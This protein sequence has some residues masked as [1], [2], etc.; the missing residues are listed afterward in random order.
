MPTNKNIFEL[1]FT[2]EYSVIPEY[3]QHALRRYVCDRI[4]PGGFLLAVLQNDLKNAC[5][6]ADDDNLALLP[7]YV[8]WLYNVAPGCCWGS[9]DAVK[10][11]LADK[12]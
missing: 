1:Y 9:P 6:R 8:K 11:W 4:S 12:A 5:G 3:A 10:A 7:I 2:G